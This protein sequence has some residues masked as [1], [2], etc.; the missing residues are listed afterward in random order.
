[1]FSGSLIYNASK[2]RRL[3]SHI[4]VPIK[5]QTLH[6][7]AGPE[8]TGHM[9]LEDVEGYLE[10]LTDTHPLQSFA[11]HGGEPFLY[12]E[13]LIQI[14]EKA[15]KLEVPRSWIITNAYWAKT[16]TIAQKKLSELKEAGL[17]CITFS[18]DGFH[19]EYIPLEKVKNG[20]EAA[21]NVGFKRVCI[22]S[23]FL[24]GANS[25]NF[26]NT[27]TK[28]AIES[29]GTLDNV[30]I[31][32]YQPRFV[33]RAAE[34]LANYVIPKAEIPIGKCQLPFWIG[35]DLKNPEVIEIDSEGNVTLCPGICI[36]NTKHQSLIQIL[37]DYDCLAHPILSIIAE[38]GP[39]GLLKTATEKGY[40]QQRKFVDECHL[41]YELRKFLRPYYPEY[42]APASCY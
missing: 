24:G 32:R 29:L 21:I 36:G 14:M 40:K 2:R 1:M 4:Q 16:K 35:G 25:D 5:M 6:Y 15:K 10:K 27:S 31:N 11:V 17:T 22:D 42:L 39:I 9:K 13:L 33:G 8:K 20:I 23:Y 3:P 41:C 38:E 7:K 18:V 28:K 19:Q 37:Q 34:L 30:E 12:F 26:Y